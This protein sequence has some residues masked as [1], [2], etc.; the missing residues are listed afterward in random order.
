LK[1]GEHSVGV[2]RQY[3]G[4]AGRIENCQVGVFLNYASRFG[5]A[6][7]DRQL[8]LP[9]DWAADAARRA[10]AAIPADRPFMTK[11]EIAR[12]LIATALEAGIPCAYVLADALYGSDK[13]LRVMLE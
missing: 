7:I 5:H 2:G 8:Y 11:P 10:K 12:D 6:L 9:K 1:K 3:S 13:S 4:T